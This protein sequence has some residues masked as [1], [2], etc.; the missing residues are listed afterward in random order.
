MEMNFRNIVMTVALIAL[1]ITLIIIGI[2]LNNQKYKYIWPPVVG[3]C[4]DYWQNLGKTTHSNDPQRGYANKQ[5]F[6]TS[7]RC[8]NVKNLGTNGTPKE[9]NPMAMRWRSG[10]DGLKDKCKWAKEHGLTWDGITDYDKCSNITN[11]KTHN[12][13]AAKLS[14][15][16]L[17]SVAIV[18]VVLIVYKSV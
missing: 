16:V 9:I 10:I 14:E 13:T 6:Y 3:E 12:M 8:V 15:Y 2:Q 17:V 5:D 11:K 4:P 18:A 7:N 1:I